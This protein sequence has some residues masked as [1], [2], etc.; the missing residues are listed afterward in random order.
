MNKILEHS[1]INSNPDRF[2]AIKEEAI[3]FCKKFVGNNIMRDDI[4]SL[5]SNFT[6]QKEVPFKLLRFPI[7]D[8]EL[9]AFTRI[10]KGTIFA[11][12]N[13]AI[14]LGKQIFAAAHELYHI[15]R[16]IETNDLDF[17]EHGSLLTIAQMENGNLLEEDKE[18]N[19]F[20]ALILAPKKSIEEQAKIHNVNFSELTFNDI[21][22]FMNLFAMPYKAMAMRFFECGF[23]NK[24]Q[25]EGLLN[26]ETNESII[27]FCESNDLET[28]WL[29]R[30]PFINNIESICTMVE[31]NKQEEV[32]TEMRADEDLSYLKEIVANLPKLQ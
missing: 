19:A 9:C 16:F 17:I 29:Q 32:V 7:D 21:I 22:L 13:T 24:A 14:P 30:T 15:L 1:L 2:S 11:T 28:R 6:K 3:A 5:I 12:I 20:A 10:K 8:T 4:F 31:K 25:T 26:S 27:Q 18:A 23:I